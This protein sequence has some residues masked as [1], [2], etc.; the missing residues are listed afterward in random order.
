MNMDSLESTDWRKR[1]Q[2]IEALRTAA[3]AE[4][5]QKLLAIIRENHRN[6]GALNAAL[7]LLMSL[8]DDVL[9]GLVGLLS[10]P[11]AEVRAYALIALAEQR[12]SRII[13]PLIQA[14]S[15]PDP[16]VRFNAVEAL[17]NLQAIEAV[18]PLLAMLRE[19][20]FYL[21]FAALEAL[22]KIGSE[23]A[24]D[25]IADLLDD[26]I[27]GPAAVTALGKLGSLSTVP[28]L[29]E[30]LESEAGEAGPTAVALVELHHRTAQL[31]GNDTMVPIAVAETAGRA[32]KEKILAALDAALLNAV[33]QALPAL[34]TVSGWLLSRAHEG[35]PS[36]A[37]VDLHIRVRRNLIQLLGHPVLRDAA[38]E[39]LK[40][41]GKEM[42]PSLIARLEDP[43]PGT[44]RVVLGA[45]GSIGDRSA[46]PALVQALDSDEDELATLAAGALGKIGERSAFEALIERLDHPSALFRQ[47]AIAAIN[48]LGHP[49]HTTRMLELTQAANAHVREAAVRSLGYFGD[50]RSLDA[51]LRACQDPALPVRLAAIE[52]LSF[53]DD[54][55]TLDVLHTAA[56]DPAAAVRAAAMRAMRFTPPDFAIPHLLKAV[57]DADMWVRI[58]TCR[59]FSHFREPAAEKAIIRLAN[60]RMPPVQAAAA[61]ALGMHGTKKAVSVLRGLLN[62]PEKEVVTRAIQ[63]LAETHHPDALA[64]LGELVAHPAL[65]VKDQVI[66]ALGRHGGEGAVK[67]LRGLLGGGHP[68]EAVFGALLR[69]RSAEATSILVG[70]LDRPN[71]RK[72]AIDA[73]S[74]LGNDALPGLSRLLDDTSCAVETRLAAAQVLQRIRST[75]ATDLLIHLLQDTSTTVRLSAIYALGEV[76]SAAAR[77]A[78]TQMAETDPD[79]QVRRR[80]RLALQ[81]I[82]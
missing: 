70:A 19:R 5:P 43:D 2:A 49:D 31:Y 7:Q 50:P 64:A 1:K 51:V 25:E 55:R 23:T 34:I 16:N 48:S 3:P 27:L 74:S 66:T 68:P 40:Q 4:L 75:S 58:H 78:L 17:G 82:P 76:G 29:L 15:D 9:P 73:V 13:Q 41:T 57:G 46:V 77:T 79:A 8:R 69:I 22:V 52:S 18:E 56:E 81:R 28:L 32:G 24:V 72:P 63:A 62:D 60:D 54:A 14:I 6:L 61:E 35:E 42:I 12:D 44:R 26:E 33:R 80:A 30:W 21:G 36:R 65:D 10:D 71:H 20:D 11:D 59:S 47:T 39:V 45:L 67:L 38:L 37:Q 53:Y